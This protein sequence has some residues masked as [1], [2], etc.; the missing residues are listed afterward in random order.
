MK[1][2]INEM[3][4]LTADIAEELL[5]LKDS[6]RDVDEI[7]CRK[8]RR[9]S[10][11]ADSN[12]ADY[13]DERIEQ[14][15]DSMIRESATEMMEENPRES[16]PS[17][18]E[19]NAEA[20]ESEALIEEARLQAELSEEGDD[21][22]WPAG[23][24]ETTASATDADAH[25]DPEATTQ[26][27][28]DTPC[29]E[30][31][32]PTPAGQATE[33]Q[34]QSMTATLSDE[35]AEAESAIFEETEDATYRPPLASAPTV[36]AI[37]P[38]QLRNSLTL[39]DL[40]LYRRVLFGGSAQHFNNAMAHIASLQSVDEIKEYLSSTWHVNLKTDEAK[41]FINSISQFFNA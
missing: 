5:S 40:F 22:E 30:T 27:A 14:I 6:G 25:T 38:E 26:P 36:P 37:S 31:D 10:F 15:T 20:E 21:D 9:L 28:S 2:Y 8:I 13:A 29:T 35:E 41:D 39:N 19:A 16:H 24:N 7:L 32:G 23:A 3:L 4:H 34:Q 33:M 12:V 17:D 18:A 1:E 11:L